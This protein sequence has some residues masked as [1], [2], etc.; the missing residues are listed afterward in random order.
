MKEIE[1]III[2]DGSPDDS[3]TIIDDYSKKYSFVQ[4]Y[5]KENGGLGS[6]RNMGL[7]LAKGD[8]IGFVDSDDY[9][10]VDM[11]EKMYNTAMQNN[12]DMVICDFSFTDETGNI[13]GTPYIKREFNDENISE[14]QYWLKYGRTEAVN[15]LYA[16]S[17]FINSSIRYPQI[18]YEDYPT[19]PL[20]IEAANKISYVS[21]PLYYY[22]HRKD[23]IMGQTKSFSEKNYDVLKGTEMIVSSKYLFTCEADYS[24]Y[25]DEVAPVYAFIRFYK[26]IF[27]I[28]E[29]NF[30]NDTIIRWGSELNRILPGWHKSKAVTNLKKHIK[31]PFKRVLL[32]LIIYAFRTRQTFISSWFA[33]LNKIVKYNEYAN[34]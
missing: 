3:Q 29:K 17:L 9:I 25:L 32:I 2:N 31:N 23:S 12:A 21:E 6:A 33:L 20:L 7:Q 24:F 14:K 18:L 26:D 13:T 11:F 28:K 30:R 27:F 19:T 15:K 4:G 5:K 1:I 34:S 8:Y 16:R 22:V 10:N